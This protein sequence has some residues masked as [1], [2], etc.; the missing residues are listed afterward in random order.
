MAKMSEA[1]IAEFLAGP[2]ICRLGCLDSAGWPYVVPVWMQFAD[3]GYYIV[4]RERA[5]WAEYLVRDDR[6]SLCMDDRDQHRRV[7]LKGRAR[8]EEEP[9]VGGRWVPILRE[10][11]ERYWGAR[12]IDYH[13]KTLDEPRWLVFVKPVQTTS[14]YGTWAQRYRHYSWELTNGAERLTS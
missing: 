8:V 13:T 1:E 6:V 5:V 2:V 4:P 12:G 9:N 3:G 7:L 10:M 11:A 14:W